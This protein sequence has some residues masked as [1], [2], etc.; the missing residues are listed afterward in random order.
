MTSS[1]WYEILS[2]TPEQEQK[3]AQL[4][5]AVAAVVAVSWSLLRLATW[6]RS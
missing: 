5:Q 1:K 3:V 6:P 4:K 2:L